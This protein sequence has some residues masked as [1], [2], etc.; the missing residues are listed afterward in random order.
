MM[1]LFQMILPSIS[2]IHI[3]NMDTPSDSI[4]G[5]AVCF[6]KE[7]RCMPGISSDIQAEQETPGLLK[8][9]T[10]IWVLAQLL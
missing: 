10:C 8:I 5:R 2:S 3:C 7:I 4:I 9:P 6:N 1:G